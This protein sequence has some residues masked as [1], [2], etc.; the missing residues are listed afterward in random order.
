[1]QSNESRQFAAWMFIRWMLET[2]NQVRWSHST[3]L[4]PVTIPAGKILEADKTVT[5][6]WAAALDLIPQAS[7]YPQ[8]GDWLLAD[9]VLAD[10]FSAYFRS[11]PNGSLA[12]VLGMMDATIWDLTQK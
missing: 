7:L 3:G 9:K 4:L 11:F 2:Q 6:Q 5:P 10:G 8:T 12:G 1:L